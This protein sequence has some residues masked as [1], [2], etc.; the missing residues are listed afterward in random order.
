MK[1][2]YVKTDT[3]H[4][5]LSALATCKTLQKR[6]KDA[7]FTEDEIHRFIDGTPPEDVVAIGKSEIVTTIETGPAGS[8]FK[9]TCKLCGSRVR[10]TDPFCW[11]CGAPLFKSE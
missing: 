7:I 6:D 9:Y 1:P 3:L 10:K 2:K 11:H 4:R 8:V 5:R